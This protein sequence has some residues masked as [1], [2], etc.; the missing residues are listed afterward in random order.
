MADIEREKYLQ[1][2][3]KLDIQGLEEKDMVEMVDRWR[4]EYVKLVNK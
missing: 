2:F 3:K 1:K 4:T